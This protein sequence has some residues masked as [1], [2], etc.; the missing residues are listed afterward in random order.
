M[1]GPIRFANFQSSPAEILDD[2]IASLDA[3]ETNQ[4]LRKFSGE[5]K[6]VLKILDLFEKVLG[7][8]KKLI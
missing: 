2:N 3:I 5:T 4:N 7:N 6:R 1:G 8:L